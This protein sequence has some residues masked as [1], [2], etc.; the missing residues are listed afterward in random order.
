MASIF[1]RARPKAPAAQQTEES[2]VSA[3]LVRTSEEAYTRAAVKLYHFP[4]SP[5][6]RRVNITIAT[7]GLDV[8]DEIV[9]ISKGES[10]SDEFL[11]INPNGK[12]PTLVDG[13]FVLWESNA[14]AQYLCDVARAKGNAEA[15]R[16]LPSSPRGRA[17]VTRWQAWQ[18]TQLGP[19]AGILTFQNL[20]KRMFMGQEPDAAEVERGL[21]LFHTSAKI[22]DASLAGR[23]W[24]VGDDVTLADLANGV[25]LMY[26]SLANIP[27]ADYP[28][29]VAWLANLEKLEA[30]QKTAPRFG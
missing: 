8:V 21:A 20:V 18:M 19:A 10:R 6:A 5:N 27:V 25:T 1:A 22:L 16:L 3:A 4:S 24:L 17:D 2:K 13:D 30:W 9:D 15:E 29:I 26:A 23:T 28:N 7:L 14:I 11:K 12:I